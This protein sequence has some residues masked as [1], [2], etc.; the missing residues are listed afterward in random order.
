MSANMLLALSNQH[1]TLFLIYSFPWNK[2]PIRCLLPCCDARLLEASL[3]TAS[4]IFGSLLC[5]ASCSSISHGAQPSSPWRLPPHAQP[6]L[7]VAAAPS[8][9]VAYGCLL[10][11][12]RGAIVGSRPAPSRP[13]ARQQPSSMDGDFLSCSKKPCR[14]PLSQFPLTAMDI[15]CSFPPMAAPTPSMDANSSSPSLPDILW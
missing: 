13:P 9:L 5:T 15:G 7:L 1:P 10:C 3:P 6:S 2:N 14:S 12:I 11:S 4:S 8:P